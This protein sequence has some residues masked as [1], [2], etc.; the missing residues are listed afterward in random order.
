MEVTANKHNPICG[1][2]C[3]LLMDFH[4]KT[5]E[6]LELIVPNY[7]ISQEVEAGQSITVTM[8]DEAIQ[9]LDARLAFPHIDLPA[10]KLLLRPQGS[11]K[12]IED[13]Q[14][15]TVS[16]SALSMKARKDSAL[17]T[18]CSLEVNGMEWLDPIPLGFVPRGYANPYPGGILTIPYNRRT[19]GFMQDRHSLSA[20]RMKDQHGNIWEGLAWE[21]EIL[22]FEPLKGLK[23]RHQYV[24]MPGLPVLMVVIELLEQLCGTKYQTLVVQSYFHP[25]NV[26]P[27]AEYSYQDY[28]DK[29]HKTRHSAHWQSVQD[30]THTSRMKTG[31]NYLHIFSAGY[32]RITLAQNHETY[33]CSDY[34][35]SEFPPVLNQTYPP[36]CMIFGK[37]E[38][39]YEMAQDLLNLRFNRI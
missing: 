15:I 30:V 20:V 2:S 31:E 26:M 14:Y 19:Q 6:K 16:H 39:E 17:P 36:L 4:A 9:I 8:K 10:A 37:S 32:R 1:E 23:F 24:T 27:G 29:W 12:V 25:E 7:G 18:V 5:E 21:S 13:E 38:L 11:V 33:R 22:D 28:Q 3:E 34:C 35:Y